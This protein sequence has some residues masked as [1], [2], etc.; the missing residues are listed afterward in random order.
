IEYRSHSRRHF[1]MHALSFGSGL[2]RTCQ[3]IDKLALR[4]LRPARGGDHQLS[5][6]AAPRVENSAGTGNFVE[7][8]DDSLK[9]C[10]QILF[11][12]LIL[13]SEYLPQA[14]ARLE[15]AQGI[16]AEVVVGKVVEPFRR[17]QEGGNRRVNQGWEFSKKQVLISEFGKLARHQPHCLGAQAVMRTTAAVELSQH[18]VSLKRSYF[19]INA[20]DGYQCLKQLFGVIPT[21]GFLP[22]VARYFGVV[23]L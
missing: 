7:R 2:L 14:N 6:R 9:R 22:P 16:S 20:R 18:Q 17:I 15:R 23:L 19:R 11:G 4:R 8:R 21:V 10:I 13:T 3:Q 12:N 1:L 5:Q